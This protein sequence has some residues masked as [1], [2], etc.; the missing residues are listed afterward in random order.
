MGR[1]EQVRQQAF[2]DR[3]NR[4]SGARMDMHDDLVLIFARHMSRRVNHEARVGR[5]FCSTSRPPLP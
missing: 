5:S 4:H 2:L 1:M 3:R